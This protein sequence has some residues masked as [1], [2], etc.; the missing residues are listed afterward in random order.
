[1]K[2]ETAKAIA[3][4]GVSTCNMPSDE[5][6]LRLSRLRGTIR[7]CRAKKQGELIA[8]LNPQLRELAAH[9][10]CMNA[11]TAGRLD[12]EVYRAL[13]SWAKRRHNDKG[14]AWI[15]RR[16]F[17]PYGG[18]AW[19][20]TDGDAVLVYLRDIRMRACPTQI[21]LPD[22]AMPTHCGGSGL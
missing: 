18:H 11:K 7:A 19:V 14:K 10:G 9:Y 2:T 3:K 13:W 21:C 12:L 6:K 5:L 16:Y 20:F 15:L 1:M 17:R 22:N 8:R 4:D